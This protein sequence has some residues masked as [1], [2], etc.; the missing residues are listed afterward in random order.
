MTKDCLLWPKSARNTDAAL[1]IFPVFS[2]S[3]NI[4]RIEYRISLSKLSCNITK[5]CFEPKVLSFW[6]IP[7]LQ[8]YH[9]I[10]NTV[11]PNKNLWTRTPTEK[12]QEKYKKLKYICLLKLNNTKLNK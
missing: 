7:I 4:T 12:Y 11:H 6:E 8:K 1:K 5:T 3:T 10:Y 2:Y 9:Y